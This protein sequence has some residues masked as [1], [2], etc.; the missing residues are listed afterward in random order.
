MEAGSKTMEN[1]T[2]KAFQEALE[3]SYARLS[4]S[5]LHY[6]EDCVGCM[7][8]RVACPYWHV[9]HKY[10]PVNKAE[11]LRYMYRRT[12]TVTGRLL[13]K[14]AKA[15][16]PEDEKNAWRM[17]ELAYKCSECDSCYIT[18]PFGIDSGE[19]INILRGILYKAGW[20]PT[21]LKLL[22]EIEVKALHLSMPNVMNLW[23]KAL[24]EAEKT[25]GSRLPLDKRAEVVFIPSFFDAFITPKAIAS[26]ALILERAGLNWT[27]PS[28]PLLFK[29]FASW[30]IGD[31]ASSMIVAERLTRYVESMGGKT[32]L[33]IDGGTYYYYMRWVYP[34]QS[35]KPLSYTV[36]HIV[37][38]VH[39][40]YSGGKLKLGKI[41]EKVT[42]HSP[43]KLGRRAGVI[44][45]PVEILRSIAPRYKDLPH[46]G[47]ETICCGGGGG[48][49]LQTQEC[50]RKLERLTGID[51]RGMINETEQKYLYMQE[52]TYYLSL[53]RK[54]RDIRKVSPNIVVTGCP[55]CVLSLNHASLL[56]GPSFQT[57]TFPEIIAESME[58]GEKNA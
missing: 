46:K 16:L 50:T 40:L 39:E 31:T 13:G 5:I 29:P 34:E 28:K 37:E 54:A 52:K 17:M 30:H 14:L 41:D 12:L 19:L 42:W 2:K 18:C 53:D 48:V 24:A 7:S 35:G 32:L 51:I 33:V 26:T 25:L 10:S 15:A 8:C 11:E 58:R 1:N 27:L 21:N 36:K 3:E 49:A 20:A 45:E 9:S 43:C 6:L 47:A 55:T 23:R 38:L 56:Y 4:M 57:L 44:R 22:S